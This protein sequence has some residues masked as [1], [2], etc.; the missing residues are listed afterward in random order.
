MAEDA[1]DGKKTSGRRKVENTKAVSGA[2]VAV[3]PALWLKF[4]FSVAPEP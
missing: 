4:R 2:A 3:A 1:A